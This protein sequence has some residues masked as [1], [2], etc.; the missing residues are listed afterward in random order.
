MR[1]GVVG[2]ESFWHEGSDLGG[3]FLFLTGMY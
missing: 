2:Q 3:Q 1:D